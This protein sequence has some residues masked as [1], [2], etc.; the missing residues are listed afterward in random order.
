VTAVFVHFWELPWLWVD[1]LKPLKT[2]GFSVKNVR[3]SLK[4]QPF[5]FCFYAI[6]NDHR[7]Y[8]FICCSSPLWPGTGKQIGVDWTRAALLKNREGFLVLISTSES[9]EHCSTPLLF[10]I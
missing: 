8:D 7:I 9:F 2:S 4:T 1:P 3:F 5:Q 6:P 10:I